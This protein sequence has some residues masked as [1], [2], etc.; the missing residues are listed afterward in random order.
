MSKR[1]R[2]VSNS[3]KRELAKIRVAD[4]VVKSSGCDYMISSLKCGLEVYCNNKKMLVNLVD[5]VICDDHKFR[6][7]PF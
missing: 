6:E 7:L 1:G 2:Y 5:C 4:S 3:Y